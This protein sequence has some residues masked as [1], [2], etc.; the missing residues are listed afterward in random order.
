MRPRYSQ[1]QLEIRTENKARREQE[2]IT[3]KKAKW[4]MFWFY[5]LIAILLWLFPVDDYILRCWKYGPF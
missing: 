4:F 3:Y 1:K 5:L 2:A